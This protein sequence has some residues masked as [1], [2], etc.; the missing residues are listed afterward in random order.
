ML[1]SVTVIAAVMANTLA[2]FHRWRDSMGQ[3][4]HHSKELKA[5]YGECV[6][7]AADD[8]AVPTRFQ[9]LRAAKHRIETCMT[10]LSRSVL[11]FTGLLACATKLGIRRRGSPEGKAAGVFLQTIQ[12]P[13]II[14]AGLMADAGAKVLGLVRG[15]DTENLSTTDMCGSIKDLLSRIRWLF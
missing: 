5:M 4:V 7:V 13:V 10:P 2:M 14:L 1:Q 12:A 15:F 3:L 9:H 11:N 6:A 8:S